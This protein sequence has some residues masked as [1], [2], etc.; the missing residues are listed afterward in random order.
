M[1]TTGL[2]VPDCI[3]QRL[4]N[5]LSFQEFRPTGNRGDCHEAMVA[6]LPGVRKAH[7]GDRA[8]LANLRG[9]SSEK[10]KKSVRS[11]ANGVAP[12]APAASTPRCRRSE[13]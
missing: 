9:G 4:Q 6:D 7:T 5:M 1:P 8:A 13:A 11:S 10:S 2:S 12:S 3:L